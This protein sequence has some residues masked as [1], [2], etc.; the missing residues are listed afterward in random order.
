M[1]IL[2][3]QGLRMRGY[4]PRDVERFRMF[5]SAKR[6]VLITFLEYFR[7]RLGESEDPDPREARHYQEIADVGIAMWRELS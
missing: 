2:F 1:R 7:V 6:A 3:D 4:D 5:S